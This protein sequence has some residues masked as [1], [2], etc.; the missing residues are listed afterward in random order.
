MTK[1]KNDLDGFHE[2]FLQ[3]VEKFLPESYFQKH[4]SESKKFELFDNPQFQLLLSHS[5]AI[6]GVF[7]NVQMR[8]EFISDNIEAITGYP[9][10]IF[11]GPDSMK[12]VLS[13]FYPEHAAI[14]TTKIFPIIYEHF[15]IHAASQKIKEFSFKA[16]FKLVKKDK[17]IIWCMQQLSVIEK[18]DLGF[19]L[20][21]LLLMSDITNLKKDSS[22]DIVITRKDDN[23]VFQPFYAATFPSLEQS[24]H[25]TKRELEILH[26]LCKGKS[27]NDIAQLL[28]ISE[29]TVNT[30]RQ[31]M[32]EK[33][34]KKNTAELI[35]Y[36]TSTG[37][38]K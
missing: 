14:Y 9:T 19:P 24:I 7:N 11:K 30:H 13:T 5:P 4:L 8:Y 34:N 2:Q 29:N 25:F 32:L 38:L 27:S 21:I 20:L 12:N 6:I 3:T 16:S 17:S 37:I 31:N 1:P 28:F 33:S 15:Q 18:D 36:L 35:S 10:E 26:L 23:G 22:P